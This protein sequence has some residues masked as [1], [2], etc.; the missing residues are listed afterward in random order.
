MGA[1]MTSSTREARQPQ[2][3]TKIPRPVPGGTYTVQ[4]LGWVDRLMGQ[5][6]IDRKVAAE[7][8]PLLMSPDE[9]DPDPEP[10]AIPEPVPGGTE[11]I[12]R[13]D[14]PPGETR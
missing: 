12:R 14:D 11:P 4:S 2:P 13:G 9:M 8:E 10:V 1:A 7:L 3:V 6:R 5:R